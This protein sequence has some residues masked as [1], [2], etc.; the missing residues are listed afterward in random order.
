MV[1]F[2]AQN[3]ISNT[4][5]RI[6]L[7]E[8][9]F[10]RK[11]ERLGFQATSICI[12]NRNEKPASLA[13]LAGVFGKRS[14]VTSSSGAAIFSIS[15]VSFSCSEESSSLRTR[16][17]SIRAWHAARSF[18]R[19]LLSVSLTYCGDH[20]ESRLS[21]IRTKAPMACSFVEASFPSG[22]ELLQC[23]KTNHLFTD[24]TAHALQ[25]G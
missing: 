1:P 10:I 15:V 17:C 12:V 4:T 9:D 11:S 23:S 5:S 6:R 18:G 19:L 21:S 2:K 22:T 8:Y 7:L 14:A 20:A 25:P 24:K 16:F 3:D 13:R